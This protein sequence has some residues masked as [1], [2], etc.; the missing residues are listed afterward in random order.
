[1][2]IAVGGLKGGV[3]KSTVATNL[4][5]EAARR[6]R[7]VLLV[8][9]D[10]QQSALAWGQL[11]SESGKPAPVVVAM[12]PTMHKPGQLDALAQGYDAVVIDCPPRGDEL[13]RSALAVAD[14]V[15]LPCG[16]SSFDAWGLAAMFALIDEA[17]RAKPTLQAAV[18]ITR[19]QV[20][21]VRGREIR[22]AL[23][24]AGHPIL[25]AELAYRVAYQEAVTAGL[26]V[27][28]YRPQDPAAGEVRALFDELR[29]YLPVS[30]RTT[31]RRVAREETAVEA[32]APEPISIAS[33]GRRRARG[34]RAG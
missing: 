25:E 8:D 24:E 12:G 11:A 5:S 2:I 7:R 21:T 9:A 22:A 3:G 29:A 10:P 23:A 34:V 14:L 30:A 26:G 16:P 19:R 31:T 4:A 32:P 1:M 33:A 15:L 28:T 6:G 20:G 17:K 18:V 13:Q 27:T